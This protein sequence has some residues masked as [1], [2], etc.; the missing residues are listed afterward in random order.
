MKCQRCQQ[1]EA[2]VH[3]TQTRQGKTTE[4]H[5]C[6][7]CAAKLGISQQMSNYF[8]SIGNLFGPGFAGAPLDGSVFHTT[9]GIPAFGEQKINN[10]VC[11]HCG[12]TYDEFRHTGLFGCSHCYDAFASQM[13]AV[14]R[15]VQG[16]THH[17]VEQSDASAQ[18][19]H[20]QRI[21]V[22][23]L[24]KLKQSLKTAVHH[25]AY[26]K[27]AKIRDEI[28]ALEQQ[29]SEKQAKGEK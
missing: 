20:D 28:H 21:K 15:R 12:Q 29:M 7:V 5:L 18:A 26:E 27:A 11:S 14:F 8:G 13:D 25:E 22:D 19:N 16:S 10:P 6:D 4:Y 3:L 17:V 23:R 1:N 24:S 9:G 2:I